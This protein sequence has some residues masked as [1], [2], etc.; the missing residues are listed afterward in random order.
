MFVC[1]SDQ[2]YFIKF[3]LA[4]YSKIISLIFLPYFSRGVGNRGKEM[5]INV[6]KQYGNFPQDQRVH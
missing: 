4:P 1:L 5:K 3:L 6:S 2:I